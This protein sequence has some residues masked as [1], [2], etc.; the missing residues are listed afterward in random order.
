LQA[1]SAKEKLTQDH[2]PPVLFLRSFY[3]DNQWAEGDYY[4]MQPA[5]W[6]AG[7]VVNVLT[8]GPVGEYGEESQLEQIFNK[9]G[10][11]I[12]IGKP[13]DPLPPLGAHRLYVHRK[14]PWKSMVTEL[15]RKAS[16]VIIELSETRGVIWELQTAVR[17]VSPHRLLLLV[18]QEKDQYYATRE[19]LKHV[20]PS[21]LP[22]YPTGWYVLDS[23][24]KGCFYFTSDWTPSFLVMKWEVSFNRTRS[25]ER[26]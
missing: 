23:R 5:P 16:V 1:P 6:L 13:G 11:L 8:R 7:G 10:P 15:M 4:T 24:I 14:K 19:T 18:P 22:T 2:R 26:G 21:P 3:N 25:F 20:F 17:I 12:A 9:V